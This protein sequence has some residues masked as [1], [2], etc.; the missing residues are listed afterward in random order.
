MNKRDDRNEVH[1]EVDAQRTVGDFEFTDQRRSYGEQTDE[2]EEQEAEGQRVERVDDLTTTP[3]ELFASQMHRILEHTVPVVHVVRS[4]DSNSVAR[5]VGGV[6]EERRTGGQG[7]LAEGGDV[8][9]DGLEREHGPFDRLVD[10]VELERQLTDADEHQK[11]IVVQLQR[12]QALA[13]F[14]TRTAQKVVGTSI[15]QR[16]GLVG[17]GGK[18]ED[19]VRIGFRT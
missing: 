4:T 9:H 14:R 10:Y 3:D 12:V 7:D 6:D 19:R 17:R 11:E 1:G 18:E 15:A 13:A 5:V 2:A 16:A 8:E